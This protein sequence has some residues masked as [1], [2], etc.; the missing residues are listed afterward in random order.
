MVQQFEKTLIINASPNT[1]WNALTDPH[2]LRQWMG[3][4][5]MEIEVITDWRTGGPIVIKGFHHMAF[6]N[7]GTVLQFMPNYL[8]KYDYLS[9]L[10]GLP[11]TPENRTTLEFMLT[12]VGEQTSLSLIISNFPT[13]S[14]FKHVNLYWRSTIEIL[15]KFVER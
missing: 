8:L 13:D 6:E 3:D 15:K 1:V 10:S 14:I 11:D 4:P 5:E 2:L 12:P 7:K 9:S